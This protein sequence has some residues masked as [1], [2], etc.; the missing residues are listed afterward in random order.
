MT[1]M[2]VTHEACLGHEA[3]P[4]HPESPGRLTAILDALKRPA[5]ADL[6]WH[7]APL[8]DK[9]QIAR[10]HPRSHIDYV[11]SHMPVEGRVSYDPDTGASPGTKEAVLRAAGAMP[12]AIDALMDGQADKVFCAVRPPGHHAEPDRVMG[13]CFFNNVVIG[14]HHARAVHGLKRVAIVDFDVHHG[15]G[16]QTMCWQDADLF[17]ASTHQAP[18]Y[19]GTGL[20]SEVGAHGNIVNVPL[21]TGSGSETFRAAYEQNIFI[22]LEHFD[23]DILLVSAGFDAHHQDPLAGIELTDDDYAWITDRLCAIA[24]SRCEGRLVS[25]LEG[26]YD[27]DALASSVSAHVAALIQAG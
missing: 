19:P 13:F 26:G 27:L 6:V 21:A 18:F 3:H 20:A 5:F 9:D 7:D 12:A 25:I 2:I 1:T 11:L 17:Y 24:Q 23:P 4:S 10:A 15:N 8:A 22:Q 14:A 16:S